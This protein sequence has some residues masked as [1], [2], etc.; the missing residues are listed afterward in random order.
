MWQ[1]IHS[2]M[3]WRT[4]QK[5]THE[6][7]GILI[8]TLVTLTFDLQRTWAVFGDVF[9]EPEGRKGR[10][11]WFWM[12]AV[13]LISVMCF[14]FTVRVRNSLGFEISTRRVLKE[15]A[16]EWHVL[17]L[18]KIFSFESFHSDCSHT[19]FFL[20]IVLVDIIQ[21]NPQKSLQS[22]W[23]NFR[24]PPNPCDLWLYPRLPGLEIRAFAKQWRKHHVCHIKK[25]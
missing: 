5:E 19:I 21:N 3:S 11:L 9:I 7:C 13:R 15:T 6:R 25:F 14:V 4:P 20:H 12:G 17:F 10:D 24:M 16:F 18:K 2:H 23:H 1:V 22:P 8:R